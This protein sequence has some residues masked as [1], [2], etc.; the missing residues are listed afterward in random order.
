MDALPLAFDWLKDCILNHPLCKPRAYSVLPARMLYLDKETSHVRLVTTNT[1]AERIE[2]ATLSHCWGAFEFLKLK[3]SNL[4]Q[5][6]QEIPIEAL[7]QTFRDS[8]HILKTLGLSYVWIDSL[9]IIQD[10][11]DDWQRE[12]QLM[13]S[14]YGSST[15]SISADGASDGS[16]GCFFERNTHQCVV[17]IGASDPSKPL[18][19][20]PS[21]LYTRCMDSLPLG[22][23]GWA[24]QE[25]LLPSRILHFTPTQ[26]IWECYM[27][28]AFES[29]PRGF[30]KLYSRHY[31]LHELSWNSVIMRF[32]R[33]QLTYPTD[34]FVAISGVARTFQMQTQDQ[35]IAG[36]WRKDLVGQLCWSCYGEELLSSSEDEQQKWCSQYIAP[37]WSWMSAY[38][39]VTPRTIFSTG[40]SV[41]RVIDVQVTLS[42]KDIFGPISAGT[43]QIACDCL[44][45]HSSPVKGGY[46][47][48]SPTHIDDME[49][50]FE[51][52]FWFDPLVD[53]RGS[54]PSTIYLLPVISNSSEGVLGLI[55]Q[56]TG[57]IVGQYTRLGVFSIPSGNGNEFVSLL[58]K[59]NPKLGPHASEYISLDPDESQEF[60]YIIEII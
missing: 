39:G 31:P 4:E 42:S 56:A 55:L 8:I 38:A 28:T 45:A 9:C 1:L 49:Q 21:D 50:D 19:C 6:K 17:E 47:E 54:A 10:D 43:L 46:F 34:K 2:Y 29:L 60:R 5:F 35:Y 52:S 16:K 30:P 20:V 58:G 23:R 7:S 48:G 40:D 59:K 3:L 51:I 53:R 13:A 12:S 27:N 25:R 26:V 24:L 36:M 32:S 44:L 22:K 41:I 14:V 57:T 33:C 37:T 15:I 18:V 11:K